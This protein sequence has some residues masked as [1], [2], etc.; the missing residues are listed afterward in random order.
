MTSP[1]QIAVI[2]IILAVML[3]SPSRLAA[4]EPA[5]D[6]SV[7]PVLTGS[8]L[9]QKIPG[10]VPE[11]FA[12]GIISTDAHEFSCC[13]SS[14]GDEF[15]FT[16][17]HPVLGQP[18]VMFSRFEG[19]VWTEPEIA[20]FVDG[21][22]SF[23][24]FITPDNKR[25]YYQSMKV[26]EGKP[27][28]VTLCVERKGNGWG[29]PYDPGSQF[30]PGKT[31]HISATSKGVIYTTDITAGMGAEALGVLKKKG[32]QYQSL[33][34]LGP[35]FGALEKEQHPWIAPDESYMVFSVRRPDQT[36]VS[37]LY[38]SFKG[39]GGQWSEPIL[40]DLGMEAGQGF[41][42]ADG[43]YLFFT[44]GEQGQGDIWWVSA[45][46]IKKLRPLEAR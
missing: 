14:F 6:S 7:F 10:T 1:R 24:P 8:Y 30:N 25:L 28:M 3:A 43:R 29:E 20:P 41:V 39:K 17:R 37:V 45:D 4:D 40:L 12:A 5:N 2:S 44:S 23:E 11:K 26:V 27:E 15:F 32:G 38:C 46:V 33:E 34:R 16:R 19:G 21:Q 42:T 9:G 31:M 22:F 36:P 18:V 35:P 13:F